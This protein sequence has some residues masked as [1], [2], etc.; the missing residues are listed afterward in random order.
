MMTG[1]NRPDDSKV[2]AKSAH[3][4]EARSDITSRLIQDRHHNDSARD[5]LWSHLLREMRALA[6]AR[7]HKEKAGHTLETD[8]L[9]NELYLKLSQSEMSI[10]D[11]SHFL[12][13]AARQLRLILV[14]HARSKKRV[15]RGGVQQQ[16]TLRALTSDSECASADVLDL[17]AALEVLQGHDELT[18]RV[19]ELHY[20]SG[21]SFAEVAEVSNVSVPTV[22]RKLRIGKAWLH[23]RLSR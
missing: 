10:N 9:V 11:R 6:H 3:P 13:V 12:A 4:D 18:A 7:L 21:L 15:K 8:A 23:Q 16:I 20:F 2:S 22:T 19:L 5:R 17:H 14:D 1:P